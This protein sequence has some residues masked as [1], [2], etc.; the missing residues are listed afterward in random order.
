MATAKK[1]APTIG[2]TTQA[3]SAVK[4]KAKKS[5]ATA[6]KQTVVITEKKPAVR[7]KKIAIKNNTKKSPR[8][9][10]TTTIESKL[11]K[12][13][14]FHTKK[15]ATIPKTADAQKQS[16][17]VS[18]R[19]KIELALLSPYRFPVD[20]QKIAV[21]A[22]RYGGIFFV[23]IGA[24]FTLL[25][26][27]HSFSIPEGQTAQVFESRSTVSCANGA[28]GG[29]N[30]PSVR[31]QDQKPKASFEVDN[32]QSLSGSVQ[33]RVAVENALSIK[34]MAYHKDHDQELTLGIPAMVS[35]GIW[36][37][38]WN[39]D[40]FEEGEYKLK[41]LIENQYG[42]YE[43][44][45]PK[46]VQV[47]RPVA[48]STQRGA[49]NTGT[50]NSN[51][52]A[53]QPSQRSNQTTENSLTKDSARPVSAS[54]S[55]DTRTVI[56][57]EISLTTQS[58]QPLAKVVPVRIE[59]KDA[60]SVEIFILPR[61]S[62]VQKYLGSARVVD[63]SVWNY[64][65]DTLGTPNGEYKVIAYV[66]NAYGSYTKETPFIQVQNEAVATFT[67]EQQKQVQILNDIKTQ[68][69]VL[70]LPATTAS[71][72]P[73]NTAPSLIEETSVAQSGPTVVADTDTSTSTPVVAVRSAFDTAIDASKAELND[74]LQRFAAALRLK[75]PKTIDDANFRLEMLKKRITQSDVEL[76]QQVNTYFNNAVAQ[77]TDTVAKVERVIIERTAEKAVL[78][79]D[80]DGISDYD[81]V[82][83]YGTNP[84]GADSDNDGFT[85]GAEI[86][87]GFDPLDP[88]SEAA[89]VYESPKEAGIIREDILEVTSIMTAEPN[90]ND[91]NKRPAAILTGKALPNSYITLYIFSTPIV[92]TIKTDPDGS[93]NY[94]FDKE[95]EDGEHH[96]YIGI[97][98]NTGKIVAKSNSFAFVKEAEAFT[99]VNGIGS[100]QIEPPRQSF[101]SEYM[102]YLVLSISVVAIG[103]VL[104]ILGLHLDSRQRRVT[105]ENK[106]AEAVV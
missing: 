42:T 46:Y 23:A 4:S 86:L 32:P 95:L 3:A 48:T 29:S 79:S 105:I 87:S 11:K 63:Q 28:T 34:M 91:E 31:P 106:P 61:N 43:S 47:L 10:T 44:V 100:I 97:T 12:V 19:P 72:P 5:T 54:S 76:T 40:Q 39:T 78:D 98:D 103:L 85:D 53:T 25:F 56:A 66:K 62:L 70:A 26:A 38:A 64:R 104:I 33:V 69:S 80:S 21:G 45:D 7:S 68:E 67:E 74:E 2:K 88:Q 82:T 101:I 6:K 75:D 73:I 24:L 20:A 59:V 49:T 35:S 36:E 14:A 41:A 50:L 52:S 81:E 96:V 1:V 27:S 93:W 90:E 57:P 65:W 77:V 89:I 99:D 60:L 55:A 92:I 51:E 18:L 83:I 13:E 71:L 17:L 94:R 15:T 30:C 8:T 9:K 22:A 58:S 16:R 102:V 84:F 37:I